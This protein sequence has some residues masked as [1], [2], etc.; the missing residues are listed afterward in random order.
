M[1]DVARRVGSLLKRIEDRNKAVGRRVAAWN[2][3]LE[4]TIENP[5]TRLVKLQ[6]LDRFLR[7]TAYADLEDALPR[8]QSFFAY[9]TQESTIDERREV[10]RVLREFVKFGRLRTPPILKQ[11]FQGKR[12]QLVR[13]DLLTDEEIQALIDACDH[14]RDRAFLALLYDSGARLDE[15]VSLRFGDARPHESYPQAFVVTFRR[16][17]T[18]LREN[19]LFEAAPYLRDWLNVHP[20]ANPAA[21]LW[22][23]RKGNGGMPK[24]LDTESARFMFNQTV[25]RARR[26]GKIDLQRRVWPHLFRHTRATRLLEMEYNESKLK[27]RLGWTLDSRMLARYV[28]LAAGGDADEEAKVHGIEIVARKHEGNLK[29]ILC[30]RCEAPNA[31]ENRFCTVCGSVLYAKDRELLKLQPKTLDE[32]NQV[33]KLAEEAEI[34]RV[35]AMS[36]EQLSTLAERDALAERV[37]QL[38][39]L[40]RKLADAKKGV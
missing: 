31:P 24:A 29:H 8:L 19:V 15:V 28:H 26:L 12:R 16:S 3:N 32:L 39:A 40:V 2:D 7:W 20:L 1:S 10:Q 37:E 17:K 36:K 18:L 5:K 9:L 34:A 27:Q 21:P 23:T 33:T 14:P 11:R 38:E 22:T 30:D 25:R 4:A 13:A 6:R 35:N